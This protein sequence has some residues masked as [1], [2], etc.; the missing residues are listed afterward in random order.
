MKTL[1]LFFFFPQKSLCTYPTCSFFFLA[2]MRK[3]AR[4]TVQLLSK[5]SAPPPKKRNQLHNLLTYLQSQIPSC[6]F[7]FKQSINQQIY[8]APH[9]IIYFT[10]LFEFVVQIFII[11]IDGVLVNLVANFVRYALSFF[12]PSSFLSFFLAAAAITASFRA[13]ANGAPLGLMLVGSQI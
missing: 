9:P 10:N 5:N 3:L 7:H 11:R 1:G 4:N 6:N 13:L 12:L 8:I 2:A